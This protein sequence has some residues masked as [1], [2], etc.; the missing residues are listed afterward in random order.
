MSADN[1]FPQVPMER[2]RN[3]GI[4]AHIDAGKTTVSERVLFYTGLTHKIGEVHEG[5][6]VMDWMDQERER[7]ITITSATTTCFWKD[8]RLNLID[9]PGHVDF[10]V[11]VE[12]SL[13]VLDG[14]VVV[15]DG[16][17][18]VEPQSET[19][20]HQADNYK[21]PR[22]CFVNKLDRTGAD[23]WKV[24]DSIHN[25]LTKETVVMTL[26]IGTEENF[27]GIVDLLTQK[28]WHFKGKMGEQIELVD[29]P[30][31]M[32]EEV[33]K[34]R[35]TMVEKIAGFDDAL[36]EKFLA[37]EEISVPELNA[38]LRSAVIA[39]KVVPVFAGSALKNK[40]VQRV[41]DAVVEYLPSPADLP[42][43]EGTDPDDLEKK[44]TR[45]AKPSEPFAALAFKVM[46]DP[47]VG[48]VTFFRVY[49]G[50]L[51][52]GSYVTNT[53]NGKRERIGR[54][55]RM[56]ANDRE[57]VAEMEA[58]GIGALVGLKYTTTGDTLADP[59]HPILL[60]RI[61][62]Q[63]PVISIAIEPKTKDDQQKMGQA[64]KSLM[65]EDPTF[66]VRSDEETGQ[67][68]MEGMG[69]LHLEIKADRLKREFGV[70]VNVGTPQV[71]YKETIRTKAEAEGKY[72]KQSGGRGQYGHVWLRVEPLERGAG[73]EFESEIKGGVIPQEYVAP[74]GK[75]VIEAAVNGVLA[76]YPIV[77]VKATLY[78]GSYHDVDSSEIAFKIAGAMA[79]REGL[80]RA[81][82]VLLEPIM[83][84]DVIT[85][86]NYM[87]DV[88]GDLNARRGQVSGI[89][90]RP[91]I[92]VISGHV[93]LA[94]MF[95]Y[96]TQL[97]SMTQGRAT[98]SMEF[99]HYEATPKNIQEEIIGATQK[100][101]A[102]KK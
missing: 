57:E 66:H 11:E 93:P 54:I 50:K 5:E 101:K 89:E 84:V 33:A 60:E 25:R 78:D 23:F 13:R 37:G 34:W 12:R 14:A 99:D 76:G 41:L 19:V 29:V 1:K 6:A 45:E 58:G 30:A 88:V 52:A 35:D 67:T 96:A 94:H 73:V 40:G 71:A 21:V 2:I 91:N 27:E 79:F 53:S 64:L 32:A 90:D 59:E 56:H 8:H 3:F 28:A 77:D 47:F 31:D 4:I 9:T 83:K 7:G 63:D 92:K 61:V 15:F 44:L 81:Q 46:T 17:A 68:I 75:G 51:T 100:E 16:V 39:S 82:P 38:A 22:M 49:S 55:L 69:E 10:T 86:E 65:D 70:E 18:G 42:P 98:Y 95:G 62:G 36:T 72:I 24:L 20:W 74:V 80:R 97:R 43:I 102:A 85:P 87:G 48:Q 26:P